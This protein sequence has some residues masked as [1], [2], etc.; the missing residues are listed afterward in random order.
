ML[1]V[2]VLT[3]RGSGR[4]INQDRVV[5]NDT[6]VDSDQPTTAM[7]NVEPPSLVA[8]LDG[9][10]GHPAGDIA[11]ALAAEVIATGSSDVETEQDL[12]SLVENANQILY[13]AMRDHKGL[14]NMGTTIAGALVTTDTAM[15]F[16]VGDSRAYLHTGDHLT[17]VTVDDWG[18]GYITQTLGGYPWF[19]PI[20]VHTI[21]V[22]LM[23]GRIL[24]ATDG[25]FG[26]TN[27]ATLSKAMKGP[28]NNVPDQLLGVSIQS[29]NTDDFSVA[30]VE[31]A[32][33][34]QT[35]NAPT[36][37]G[38]IT[39]QDLAEDKPVPSY[40]G[41]SLVNLVAEL[42]LRLTGQSPTAGLRS[43]LAGLIP[44]KRNYVLV[45]NDGLGSPQLAHPNADRLRRCHSATL[46]APFPTTTTVGLSSIATGMAPMQHGV[47]G[48][49][50]NGIDADYVKL[51]MKAFQH[52]QASVG[53]YLYFSSRVCWSEMHHVLLEG[54]GL[55]HL[56]LQGVPYSLRVKRPQ[57]LYRVALDDQ[58]YIQLDTQLETFR[59][60]LWLDYSLDVIDVEDPSVD[61]G[62]S[63][64][65][66]WD[67]AQAVWSHVLMEV[68]DAYVC[69]AAIGIEA[70]VF[71]TSDSSLR[72]AL[73]RI[74]DPDSAW[75]TLAAS[76]KVALGMEPDEELPLPLP[77]GKALPPGLAS[78]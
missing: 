49:T 22:P 38:M 53:D 12:I 65:G 14:R 50:Q 23:S 55:E 52:L 76:L 72:D 44:D 35:D 60:A 31:P 36:Q 19:H 26:R 67:D 71:I 30:V 42:E 74:R 15:V 70:D 11:A 63:P 40:E 77:P 57:V 32:V 27:R 7:F 1:R 37:P 4:R 13:E 2:A 41:D 47:I 34:Q 5:V 46:T 9:L 73:K 48:Y 69:A 45:I 39:G 6:V 3:R 62:M 28:L 58:D 24:A 64:D 75:T 20:E 61:L 25:L 16:H 33:S 51:G 21:T 54:R 8:V 59:T 17:Q 10:G 68:F 29:G 43:D 78:P 66:I 18:E 56:K